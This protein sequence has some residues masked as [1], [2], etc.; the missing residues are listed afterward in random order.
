VPFLSALIRPI[1]L[2]GAFVAVVFN[3]TRRGR[4]T[5]YDGRKGPLQR[6]ADHDMDAE[7]KANLTRGETWLR[8]V[9]ILLFALIYSLAELVLTAVVVFQFATTLVTGRRNPRVLAFGRQLSRFGYEVLLY[10][11]FNSD[12]KPW[13]F[14]PWPAEPSAA[15]GR[16]S[17]QAGS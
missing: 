10:L 16:D 13:P 9:F 2:S 4:K 1:F 15:L 7:L 17:E 8:G 3:H 6:L 5:G 14:G 11:T 12:D